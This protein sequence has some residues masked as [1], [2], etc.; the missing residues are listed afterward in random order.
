[1]N[2]AAKLHLIAG[3]L[4]YPM[5]IVPTMAFAVSMD[6][7]TVALTIVKLWSAMCA[8]MFLSKNVEVRKKVR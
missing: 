2:V 3:V 6:A 4:V 8:L 1:M 7:I 5:S